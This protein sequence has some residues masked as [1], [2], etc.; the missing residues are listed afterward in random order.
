MFVCYYTC[1]CVVAHVCVLL[2]MLVCVVTHVS[3][4]LHMFVCVLHMLV[5][6]YT[7]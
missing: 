2:H 6:S 4:C 3:V 7:C 5:C 1:L